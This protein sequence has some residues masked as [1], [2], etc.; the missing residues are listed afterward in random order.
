MPLSLD[1]ILT[2]QRTVVLSF[3]GEDITVTYKPYELTR[4]SHAWFAAQEKRANLKEPEGVLSKLV[5]RIRKLPK[6]KFYKRV[7]YKL[8]LSWDITENGQILGI[9]RGLALLPDNFI[10]KMY[11]TMINEVIT[12]NRETLNE[13]LKKK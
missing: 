3:G 9:Q 10:Q 11:F 1:E 12:V 2:N 4:D 8:I 5:W 13:P 7:L 6:I